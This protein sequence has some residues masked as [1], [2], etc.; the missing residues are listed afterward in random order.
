METLSH[1]IRSKP[2]SGSRE[3]Q[4]WS[5][6]YS[7]YGPPNFENSCHEWPGSRALEVNL[8]ITMNQSPRGAGEMQAPA[9]QAHGGLGYFVSGAINDLVDDLQRFWLLTSKNTCS[10]SVLV[11]RVKFEL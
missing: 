10:H 4:G 6:E 9:D 1:P 5:K 2:R 8:P 7:R 11:A 3:E